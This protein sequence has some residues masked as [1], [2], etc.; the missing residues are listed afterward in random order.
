[1][2]NI[3][4]SYRHRQG[5]GARHTGLRVAA[6]SVQLLRNRLVRLARRE[7]RRPRSTQDWDGAL[8][9]PTLANLDGDANVE[10]AIGATNSGLVA[11]EI[12]GSRAD[13]LHWPTGRGNLLRNAPEPGAAPTAVTALGALAAVARRRYRA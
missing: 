13:R 1:M 9:A 6:L 2:R 5:S 12:P 7:R 8:G 10:V 3:P 11:Y 4:A